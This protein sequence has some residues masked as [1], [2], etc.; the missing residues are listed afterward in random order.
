LRVSTPEALKTWR[1][2]R[3]L[4]YPRIADPRSL[5]RMERFTAANVRLMCDE[6]LATR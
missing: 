2:L 5:I 4:R 3:K 1:I 6:S